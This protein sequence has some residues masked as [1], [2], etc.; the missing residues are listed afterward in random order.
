VREIL[1]FRDADYATTGNGLVN[2]VAGMCRIR[3][4]LLWTKAWCRARHEC[5]APRV[6]AWA[7]AED[8]SLGE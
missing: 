6:A 2:T 7:V 1:S 4:I 5:L 8:S 3:S